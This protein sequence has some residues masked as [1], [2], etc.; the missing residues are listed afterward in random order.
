M[1]HKLA[2]ILG[3]I[4]IVLTLFTSGLTVT[5]AAPEGA[6]V[7]GTIRIIDLQAKTVTIKK[8]DGTSITL[9]AVAAT[10]IQRNRAK[11]N[12]SGLSLHDKITAKYNASNRNAL[13]LKAKGP[14]VKNISGAVTAASPSNGIV[15]VGTTQ[16]HITSGTKIARNGQLVSLSSVTSQDKLVAHV[17]SGTN[18][19]YDLV[20]QG[21]EEGEVHGT[22]SAINGSDVTIDPGN[23]AAQV[24]IM[25]VANTMIE[26]NGEKGT[27]ADLAVGQFAEAHYDPT[28]MNAYELEAKTMAQGEDAHLFGTVAAVDTNAGTLTITPNG[29]GADVTLTVTPSTEIQVNDEGATLAD[30]QVGMPVSA[31][32]DTSSLVAFEIKAGS[33]DDN[34]EDGEVQGTVA[35][36]DLTAST[37]TIT[38][39]GGGSAVTVNIVADTELQVNGEHGTLADVQVGAPVKAHYDTQTMNAREVQV[40]DDEGHH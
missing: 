17:Q 1:F 27:L 33:G 16:I 38:P 24:T 34:Q 29:G 7:K 11:S 26:V 35:A 9:N 3:G 32:Y 13:R 8:A 21:P 6:T 2:S 36:V 30:I 31:E 19:A 12:L 25:I 5:H 4:L 15:T 23:G 28:T 14:A 10:A 18:V 37:L 20:D 39:N 40:G 22:I